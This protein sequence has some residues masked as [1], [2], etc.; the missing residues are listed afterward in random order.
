MYNKKKLF[1]S[2]IKYW[3]EL[4]PL[5]RKILIIETRKP[6]THKSKARVLN[7]RKK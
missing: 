4:T 1:R 6:K 3:D 5:Q 2:L 7:V